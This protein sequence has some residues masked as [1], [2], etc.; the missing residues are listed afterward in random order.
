MNEIDKKYKYNKIPGFTKYIIFRNGQI[1]VNTNF[2]NYNEGDYIIPN[3]NNMTVK[4]FSD[5]MKKYLK[6]NLIELLANVFI[7]YINLPLKYNIV[8]N[9]VTSFNYIVNPEN[10]IWLSKYKIQINEKEFKQT[11][12]S[13]D[14]FISDDGMIFNYI[15]NEFIVYSFDTKGYLKTRLKGTDITKKHRIV[16]SEFIGKLE[17]NLTIDHID[18]NKQNNHYSNLEQI[19]SEENSK[20]RHFRKLQ[21]NLGLRSLENIHLICSEMEKNTDPKDIQKMLGITTKE[22]KAIFTTFAHELR[23]GRIYL[24]ITSQYD[25]SKYDVYKYLTNSKLDPYSAYI[26]YKRANSGESIL[27]LSKEYNVS[28][29]NIKMIKDKKRWKSHIE[30]YENDEIFSHNI[31]T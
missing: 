30:K 4:L 23:T 11:S 18:E 2:D 27:T 7:G 1:Q 31:S 13:R 19:T 3:T 12:F 28:E 17:S 24:D 15:K 20:R 14:Y 5:K 8:L 6:V 10:I 16:Y 22:Q 26:I 29:A 9:S 25:F 21:K